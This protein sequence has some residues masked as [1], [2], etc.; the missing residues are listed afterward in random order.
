MV[1]S[2]NRILA[3]HILESI[4]NVEIPMHCS[5]EL[6]L[7]HFESF[8]LV[9]I[10]NHFLMLR[11]HGC[12][13]LMNESWHEEKIGWRPLSWKGCDLLEQLQKET[14]DGM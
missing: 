3:R 5:D 10:K 8:R 1:S 11:R 13:L 14:Q 12:L 4:D 6:A 9:E 2:R 7:K